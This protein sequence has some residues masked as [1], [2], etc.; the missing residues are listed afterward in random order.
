[1]TAA[2]TIGMGMDAAVAGIEAIRF[3]LNK[4]AEQKCK[5]GGKLHEVYEE[6][7]SFLE[8]SDPDCYATMTAPAMTAMTGG[9]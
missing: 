4:P 3:M 2:E 9:N 1:M 8:C 6:F 5:C 7:G